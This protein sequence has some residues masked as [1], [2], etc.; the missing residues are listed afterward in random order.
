VKTVRS[1]RRTHYPMPSNRANRTAL[2]IF[3]KAFAATHK[4][5]LPAVTIE[6]F[7]D[8][9]DDPGSILCNRLEPPGIPAVREELVRIRARP[10]VASVLIRIHETME[11]ETTEED[12]DAWP[13]AEQVLIVTKASP[14]AV[15]GWFTEAIA[16]DEVWRAS[17]AELKLIPCPP[18]SGAA[19][20]WWD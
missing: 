3:C 7:F 11:G 14:A 19:V 10:D 6:Q 20:V 1:A 13:F 2:V 5:E 16:P 18:G 8:G 15:K 4:D 12:G 17:A 9:N